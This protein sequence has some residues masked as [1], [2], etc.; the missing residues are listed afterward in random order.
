MLAKLM[1][2]NICIISIPCLARFCVS[3][4]KTFSSFTETIKNKFKNVDAHSK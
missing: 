2:F 4:V 3:K 1:F